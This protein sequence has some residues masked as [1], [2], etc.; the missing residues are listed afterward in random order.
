MSFN[1]GDV[2]RLNSG[3][4]AMTVE[5]G[6]YDDRAP[7]GSDREDV[8]CCWFHEGRIQHGEFRAAM[9]EADNPVLNAAKPFLGD[10]LTPTA[11]PN[12]AKKLL[13]VLRGH[14]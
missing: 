11:L 4:P 2:V 12:A 13:S 9:L 6:D 3:S 5:R 7:A 10:P 1:V 8:R 14:P